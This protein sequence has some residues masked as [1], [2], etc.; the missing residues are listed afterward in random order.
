AP[1]FPTRP[2][3]LIRLE[4]QPHVDSLYRRRR[5]KKQPQIPNAWNRSADRAFTGVRGG[6]NSGRW[7]V[8]SRHARRPPASAPPCARVSHAGVLSAG[9][10][11]MSYQAKISRASPT[12][13]LM[14]VDQSTSMAQ[15]LNGGQ[16]KAAFLADVLNKTLYTLITNCSKADGV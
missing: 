2:T 15:R 13:I 9:M 4:F 5:K 6:L 10:R 14:V 8:R 3:L 16:S 11:H 7:L 1:A 12:A